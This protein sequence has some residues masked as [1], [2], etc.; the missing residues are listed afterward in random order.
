MREWR[1]GKGGYGPLILQMAL[2]LA[3]HMI[4]PLAVNGQVVYPAQMAHYPLL[5]LW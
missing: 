2:P 5:R 4:L 3:L 1:V